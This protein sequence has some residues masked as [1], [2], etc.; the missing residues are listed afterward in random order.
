M[1]RSCARSSQIPVLGGLAHKKREKRSERF[2]LVNETVAPRTQV[3]LR[4]SV[5]VASLAS[6]SLRPATILKTSLC[7]YFVRAKL[8]IMLLVV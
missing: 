3:R 7:L 5:T 1:R 4:K 8:K 6:V 2:S